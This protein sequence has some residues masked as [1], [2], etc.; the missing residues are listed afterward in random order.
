MKKIENNLYLYSITNSNMNNTV[1]NMNVTDY[2]NETKRLI[3]I[4]GDHEHTIEYR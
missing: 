3:D 2:I 4:I 1:S